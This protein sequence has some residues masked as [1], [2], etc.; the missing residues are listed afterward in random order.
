MKI[1]D[2]GRFFRKG[3]ELGS[4][5]HTAF[6][7]AG[8]L[9]GG[10]IPAGDATA[11]V[12]G[13]YGVFGK[14]DERAFEILLANFEKNN[15]GKSQVVLDYLTWEFREADTTEEKA[16]Q[17]LFLNSFRSHVVQLGTS[18]GVEVG[19]RTTKVVQPAVAGQPATE[20]VTTEHLRKKG[21]NHSLEFLK[22]MVKTIEAGKTPE[23]GYE[24]FRSKCI[25]MGAPV[26]PQNAETLTRA[27]REVLAQT[28]TFAGAVQQAA[29]RA[30]NNQSG[31][32][33]FIDKIV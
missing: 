4:H 29:E 19:T 2:L 7:L 11:I 32:A 15:P 23:A 25:V 16:L 9:K 12:K 17:W 13:F 14:A 26:M 6:D 33:R 24:A 8:V 5:M 31:F 20:A 10:V 27:V 18:S 1:S 3:A 22:G 28:K 30:E 21:M